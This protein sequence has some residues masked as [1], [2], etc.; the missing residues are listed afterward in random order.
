MDSNEIQR[1]AITGSLLYAAWTAYNCPCRDPFLSCHY[2]EFALAT[3]LPL[4][5]VLAINAGN[6]RK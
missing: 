5:F 2:I 6:P 3:G 1:Y 4:A